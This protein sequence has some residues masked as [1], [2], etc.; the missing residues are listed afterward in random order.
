MALLATYLDDYARVRLAGDALG[1]APVRFE[2]QDPSTFAWST[3][4]GGTSV[5]PAAG[6]AT[7]DDP[8]CP[9]QVLVAYR[10]VTASSG[11]VLFTAA[12]VAALQTAWLRF[13]TAPGCSTPVTLLGWGP[14]R[15]ATR[16]EA[17]AVVGRRNAVFDMDLAGPRT[18]TIGLRTVGR[19]AT[20]ALD[21]RMSLGLPVLLSTFRCSLGS[22]YC[23]LGNVEHDKP[24]MRSHVRNWSVDITETDP[25]DPLVVGGYADPTSFLTPW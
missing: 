14:I 6:A 17:H 25:P 8:E 1:A 23:A 20:D 18:T 4:R 7:L 16:S 24:N 19:V 13:P 12:T 11:A 10:V 2:R 22:W 15:R 3:V 9:A 21:L 5:T